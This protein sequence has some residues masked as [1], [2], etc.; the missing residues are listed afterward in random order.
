[1]E[2]RKSNSIDILGFSNCL[3]KLVTLPHLVMDYGQKKNKKLKLIHRIGI[4]KIVPYHL[5]QNLNLSNVYFLQIAIS[6][7]VN[8]IN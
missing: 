4:T 8:E 1:M 7:L 3:L 5:F 2:F 6:S